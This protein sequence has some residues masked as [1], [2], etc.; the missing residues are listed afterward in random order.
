MPAWAAA[1]WLTLL[2]PGIALGQGLSARAS[3]ELAE[4]EARESGKAVELTLSLSQAVPF[5]VFTLDAPRR[6]VL[7]FRELDWTG[8]DTGLI[9][10][11][12]SLTG[13]RYGVYR[14]GWS[15]IVIDLGAPLRL[16]YADMHTTSARNATL[17]LRLEPASEAAFAASSGA[18]KDGLWTAPRAALPKKSDRLRLVIDPGHGG[19]D[20]GAVREGVEEK[21]LALDFGRALRKALNGHPRFDVVMTRDEDAFLSLRERVLIARDARADIFLSLHANTVTQGDARGAAVYFLS[22]E[23]SDRE[24]AKLAEK[25]NR[26]DILGGVELSGEEDVVARILIDLAQARTNVRSKLLGEKLVEGLQGSIGVIRSRPLR[27][28]GFEVLK[29]PE[30]PSVLLEMGFLSNAHDRAA[31]QSPKWRARAVE[32]VIATLEAWAEADAAQSDL[33][34]Q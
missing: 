28:A 30:I 10:T 2:L 27:S 7:D 29:A 21:R 14:P 16:A 8:F 24:A 22:E 1:L 34:L 11:A 25:E 20:P 19:I 13:L 4:S 31:M 5:R 12:P 18:P 6:L 3:V 33:A 15:R 26:A 17:E 23:A 32:G 9:D